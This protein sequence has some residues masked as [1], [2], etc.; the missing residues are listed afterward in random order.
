MKEVNGHCF[1]A[2]TVAGQLDIVW[3][4]CACQL[5]IVSVLQ[6]YSQLLARFMVVCK[7]GIVLLIL[8]IG[9]LQSMK[10]QL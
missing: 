3:L 4:H 6:L 10:G 9:R 7:D 1:W 5:D 8:Q 2:L